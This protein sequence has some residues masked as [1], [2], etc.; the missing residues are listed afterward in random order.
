M[1]VISERL[2]AHPVYLHFLGS[3]SVP[4]DFLLARSRFGSMTI[5]TQ[6]VVQWS[7]AHDS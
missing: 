3:A 7:I 4:V 1:F 5:L 6:F 2:F